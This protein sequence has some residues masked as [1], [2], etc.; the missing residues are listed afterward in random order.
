[1]PYEFHFTDNEILTDCFYNCHFKDHSKYWKWVHC[2]IIQPYDFRK[3]SVLLT[4]EIFNNNNNKKTNRIELFTSRML[5]EDVQRSMALVC[6]LCNGSPASCYFIYFFDILFS[7]KH[8]TNSIFI[9]LCFCNTGSDAFVP[10]VIYT[11]KQ[12]FWTVL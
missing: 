6:L 9:V 7:D 8:S 5:P 2:K 11:L 4:V 12:T 1:M 10:L 3:N